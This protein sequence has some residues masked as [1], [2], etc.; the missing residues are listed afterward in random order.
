MRVVHFQRA[1]ELFVALISILVM[2]GWFVQSQL[3]V[4]LH[5]SFH[6]MQ[7]NTA[8]GFLMCA[9]MLHC[10]RTKKN[11]IAVIFAVMLG[12]FYGLT[13]LQYLS[14]IDI[15]IDKLFVDPFLLHADA[16]PGRPGANTT[17]CFL[18]LSLFGFVSLSRHPRAVWWCGLIT[19]CV[20][21]MSLASLWGYLVG[22]EFLAGWSS[23]LS[24][25]AVHTAIAYLLCGWLAY[26]YLGCER[27][28]SREW[29]SAFHPVQPVLAMVIM[30]LTISTAMRAWHKQ[31]VQQIIAEKNALLGESMNHALSTN[32]QAYERMVKRW[33]NNPQMPSVAWRVDARGYIVDLPA[34]V[35]MHLR[36]GAD[37]VKWD[38][39]EHSENMSLITR[40]TLHG[41]TTISLV[42][43]NDDALIVQQINFGLDSDSHSSLIAVSS[44]RRLIEELGSSYLQDFKIRVLSDN[45]IYYATDSVYTLDESMT[46]SFFLNIGD[47]GDDVQ[48]SFIPRSSF[49]I[50]ARSP[51][52]NA[53]LIG[54]LF[55]SGI[56]WV[57]V[58]QASQLAIARTKAQQAAMLKIHAKELEASNAELTA[59]NSELEQFTYSMSHD[60]KSPLL[61]INGYMK[62]LEDHLQD[63]KVDHKL[64]VLIE[65][66]NRAVNQ[67]SKMIESILTLYKVSRHQDKH[68][69]IDLS[70][71]VDQA[72]SSA[73][74]QIDSAGASVQV[75]GNPLPVHANQE[76]VLSV[77]QNLIGNA[78][79]YARVDGQE[80]KIHISTTRVGDMVQLS[81]EDNGPGIEPRFREK[82]FELFQRL[83]D[84]QADGTGIG[85]NI[86]NKVAQIHSG[87]AWVE[88]S[89]LGGAKFS[90]T[91][92]RAHAPEV[93]PSN[94]VIA[95][96]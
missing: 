16:Y 43:T 80:L 94:Q 72:V 65:P 58:H 71:I 68:R 21:G 23:Y 84:A 59:L 78:M 66:I 13:L 91:L 26:S 2:L 22:T 44:M 29:Y 28:V 53:V 4:Q 60:L 74:Y 37:G 47:H 64:G 81:V 5:P 83:G 51:W 45:T 57:M 20:V 77:L 38:E 11:Q 87:R 96:A 86:V 7:F 42:S 62:M 12:L 61:C 14:D 88:E 49:F 48:L 46:S 75:K 25:M 34:L 15:G 67:M 85:L 17:L 24:G 6:P 9:C 27:T 19:T 93:K 92:P 70:E 31:N 69:D 36:S 54:G 18:L 32:G 56:V 63:M 79:K 73:E 52:P 1:T 76:L 41:S 10:L 3:V 35:S 55:L 39:P 50:N 33:Q 95:V 30:T 82:V 89:E 40:P 90:I 8:L